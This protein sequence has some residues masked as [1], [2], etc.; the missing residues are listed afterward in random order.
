M[1]NLH[2]EDHI[3]KAALAGL[4]HDTGENEL[5]ALAGWLSAGASADQPAL[6]ASPARQLISIFDSIALNGKPREED[7]HYLPLKKLALDDNV[8]FPGAAQPEETHDASYKALLQELEQV[9]QAPGD[10]ET[11][12]ENLL[13]AMQCTLWCV[14]ST[15]A[16]DV[17]RFDQ[18]RMT[19][20]LAVC[21]A[22]RSDGDIG[23]LLGAVQRAFKGEPQKDDDQTLLD[24]PVAL[25]VGGDISG[26]QKFIYTLSSKGAAKTLRG[27][28][29]Y[30]QLLT[31]AVMRYTLRQLKIPATNVIYS[32]GGHFYLLVP[33]SAKNRLAEIQKEITQI[34]LDHHG[35]SLYLALGH[36]E[37]PASGFKKGHFPVFWTEM[38][39]QLT[40]A[41]QHRYIELKDKLYDEVFEPKAHGG[42]KENT[43]S[44]C[45]EER[46]KVYDLDDSDSKICSLCSSFE[47]EIGKNLP[48]AHFVGLGFGE[49]QDTNPGTALDVL[50]AFGMEIGWAHN[51]G[52]I[53]SFSDEVERAVVWALDDTKEWPLVENIP[54][55]NMTR[56][57]VNLIPRPRDW[58]EPDEINKELPKKL[59][60]DT[61]EKARP[62]VPL[63]FTHLQYQSKGIPRLGVLRMDV[64]DLGDI[65]KNGFGKA[66]KSRAT[67]QGSRLSVSRCPCFSKAG[68][69]DCARN[70][71]T[72]FTPFMLAV[73]MSS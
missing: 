62:G 36:A 61:D 10:D 34:L 68:S 13:A 63:T 55:A 16:P 65:F 41:K 9:T 66:G 73:T 5:S 70:I 20:A 4:S 39:Q 60:E 37:V 1:K 43:C 53:I 17:S 45:G 25:L 49:P 69:S 33:V 44:V 50:N 22:E 42:N 29:F 12:L 58:A 52:E 67:W 15:G 32:G 56:Y 11:Y 2:I 28:S 54:A 30:L 40:L 6:S 3:L 26:V 51:A 47:K 27:R 8:I 24:E 59:R 19:A 18:R 57:T 23:V 21:L 31:E 46:E 71:R 64:D 14:P 7:F 48:Q 38:H 35:V 72:R